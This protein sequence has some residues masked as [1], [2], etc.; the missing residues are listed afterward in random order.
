M[1]RRHRM[2]L[3]LRQNAVFVL[4]GALWLAAAWFGT[5]WEFDHKLQQLV[6]SGEVEAQATA[7]AAA[8]LAPAA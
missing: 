5:Q 4:L 7:D 6:K 2:G 8:P 1:Q 3:R